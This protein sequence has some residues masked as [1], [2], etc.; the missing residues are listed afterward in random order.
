MRI[1]ITGGAGMII[2]SHLGNFE[3]FGAFL[4]AHGIRPLV[5]MEEIEPPA[6]FE[7]LAARRGGRGI[8]LV[9]LSRARPRNAVSVTPRL[10]ALLS[11]LGT[12]T[13]E[14]PPTRKLA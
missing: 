2:S 8:E 5:P 3:P 13:R 10:A 11:S 9:P 14:A 1:V 7:F 4:A 6:L 12:G